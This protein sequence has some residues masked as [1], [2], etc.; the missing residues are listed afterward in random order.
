MPISGSRGAA[1]ASR[2]AIIPI[3]G[4]YNVV[5][6]GPTASF[7]GAPTNGTAPL[8]VTFTQ[9]HRLNY[10]PGVDFRGWGHQ[11][12]HGDQCAIYLQ[13]GRDQYGEPDCKWFGGVCY[14]HQPGYI[15]V[16][17]AGP[18]PPSASFTGAP[19]SGTEPLLVNFTDTST[20]TITSRSWDFGDATTT[21]VTTNSVSHTYAAGTYTV[22]LIVTGT[23]GASTNLQPNYITVL[24]AFQSWQVQYFGSTTSPAAAQNADPLG[25]GM[26]NLN[27]FLAGINPT[28]SASAFRITSV[29]QQ[30]SDVLVTWTTAGGYTNV[31]QVNTGLRTV[32][33]QPTSST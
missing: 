28:N 24:T 12:Y 15:V 21:N 31:V 1:A 26:S 30:G 2:G 3:V 29:V 4:D 33:M 13:R 27:Q 14:Q 8:T 19:T 11:Q 5:P 20:G 25:K 23:G 17:S 10:H 7:S 22:T 18:P 32:P 16:G 6:T 9:F